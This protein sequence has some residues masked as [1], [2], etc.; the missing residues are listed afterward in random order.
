MTALRQMPD[1][2]ALLFMFEYRGPTRHQAAKTPARPKHFRLDARSLGNYEC[3]GRSYLIRFRDHGRV[4]QA[5]IYLGA[6]ASAQTRAKVLD[7]LDSL[8][9]QSATP[10]AAAVWRQP[11]Q[12]LARTPYLGVSCPQANSFTCDR[13]GL[14]VWLR[15]SAVSV[16]VTINEHHFSARRSPV[17]RSRPPRQTRAV[18]GFLQ[19][20]GLLSGPLKVTADDGSGR[21]IGGKPVIRGSRT[22]HRDRAPSVHANQLPCH[23]TPAGARSQTPRLR[24][25][26]ALITSEL[27]IS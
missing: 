16:A 14:A 7:A 17:E 15:H 20:A 8:V 27:A 11:K 18:A 12:L 24:R 6:R 25:A 5:H 23:F 13:V 22:S 1:T 4:F 3:M 21:W 26:T 19:P 9:V 10:K 2:G